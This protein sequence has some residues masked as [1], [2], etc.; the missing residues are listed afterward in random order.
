[1]GGRV[2]SKWIPG[3]VLLLGQHPSLGMKCSGPGTGPKPTHT[4]HSRPK[5]ACPHAHIPNTCARTHTHTRP[6]ASTSGMQR[7]IHKHTQS[8]ARTPVPTA[9][10]H[11]HLK[12]AERGAQ[13]RGGRKGPWSLPFS[14][15]PTPVRTRDP[16]PHPL[17]D[18]SP[19]GP[20]LSW[21]EMCNSR[22]WHPSAPGGKKGV[23]PAPILGK[24]WGWA[25]GAAGVKASWKEALVRHRTGWRGGQSPNVPPASSTGSGEQLGRLGKAGQG[26]SAHPPT[27]RGSPGPPIPYLPKAPACP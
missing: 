24:S 26:G 23:I 11:V 9:L 15:A 2:G 4:T 27:T 22:G 1:M 17:F 5:H 3:V 6:C 14:E 25:R 18:P 10:T 19:W 16:P 21:C 20:I 13:R 8:E 12:A 7:D